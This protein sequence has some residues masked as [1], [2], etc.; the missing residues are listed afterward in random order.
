MRI[1]RKLSLDSSS[2]QCCPTTRRVD[3]PTISTSAVVNARHDNSS[4]NA[5]AVQ[6]LQNGQDASEVHDNDTDMF[7]RTL[8]NFA[9]VVM[10]QESPHASFEQAFL[11][12]AVKRRLGRN[13]LNEFLS[14]FR[15]YNI[16]NFPK[17]ARTCLG[18]LRKVEA[19]HICGGKYFHF[20]LSSGLNMTLKHMQFDSNDIRIQINVDG[21]PLSKSSSVC[22][23][24]LLC[25]ALVGAKYVSPVFLVGLFCGS[26]KPK[27][28]ED[29]LHLFM[30][31]MQTAINEGI[32]ISGKVYTVSIHSVVCDA[33]ARQFLKCIIGHNGYYACE[34]CVVK[35]NS[36]RVFKVLSHGVRLLSTTC[37]LRSNESFRER[38]NEPH[39]SP[40][41]ISP[42]CKLPIDMI[43]DFPLDYMHLILLG[44]VRRLLKLWLGYVKVKKGPKS[45][46][47]KL[48]KTQIHKLNQQQLKFTRSVPSDFQR[49]PRLFTYI[50]VFKATEF[51]TFLC[52]SAPFVLA[53]LFQNQVVYDHFMCLVVS[54][55]LLCTP[56]LEDH[57]IRFAR[58][59]L[60]TFVDHFRFVY[61]SY[62][63][64]YNIHSAVHLYRDYMN[65][66][67]LD[68]ISSFPY[69]S[70]MQ[71]LKSY[72]KRPGNELEQVVKRLHESLNFQVPP[73]QIATAG[74]EL[75]GM[76]FNGPLGPTN[77]GD[78][79]VIQYSEVFFKGRF[80]RLDSPNCF[81]YCKQ[82]YCRVVNILKVN[83]QHVV[84]VVEPFENVSDV[85][86]SPC[87]SS[88]L[89]IVFVRRPQTKVLLNVHISRVAK[90]W[91]IECHDDKL[92]MVR[93]L[94]ESV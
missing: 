27:P 1:L 53:D 66:G 61:G 6:T 22:F 3:S 85:F 65:F 48:N 28:V 32:S 70:Y 63:V 52:Y 14:V 89:G 26:M 19:I 43:Y 64:V 36:C 16:G 11:Q 67:C 20:G 58:R 38:R 88:K 78:H 92:Y 69:E 50:K 25:R 21:L 8:D 7:L 29:F 91:C 93:L 49:K 68:S 82:R 5:S 81:V 2:R 72:V 24:P 83:Q 4:H 59:C 46:S 76:H 80:F 39:H 84:F 33:P 31:D 71:T 41:P 40:G 34:R 94:H 37:H 47:F 73:A 56:D 12:V 15:Q 10:P 87:K 30:E 13:T 79:D 9:P 17:D 45:K 60:K 62:N 23:W 86:I 74:A 90:C 54:I 18:S 51:R 35:G 55:R 42:F 77:L 75:K 44:V 57:S